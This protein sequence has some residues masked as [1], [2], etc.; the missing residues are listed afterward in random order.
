MFQIHTAL[1]CVGPTVLTLLHLPGAQM[2]IHHCE[3]QVKQKPRSDEAFSMWGFALLQLAVIEAEIETKQVRNCPRNPPHDVR[4]K[5]G[6]ALQGSSSPRE[7]VWYTHVPALCGQQ[8]LLVQCRD[9]LNQAVKINPVSMCPDGY[10]AVLQLSNAYYV[11]YIFEEVG[12]LTNIKRAH[13]EARVF[14]GWKGEEQHSGEKS[15]PF[16]TL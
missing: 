12:T 10:L 2:Q 5:L 1:R 16:A 3:I 4:K 9:K 13:A 15:F 8:T 6:S 7:W 11:S 14:D